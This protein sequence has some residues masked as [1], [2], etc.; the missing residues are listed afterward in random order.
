[1][2]ITKTISSTEYQQSVSRAM[3]N[4]QNNVKFKPTSAKYVMVGGVPHKWS[5]GSLVSL[6]KLSK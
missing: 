5:N 4:P 3:T 6:T 1:M 2:T